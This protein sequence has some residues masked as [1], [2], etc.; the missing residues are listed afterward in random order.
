MNNSFRSEAGKSGENSFPSS[1]APLMP[2]PECA[3]NPA[4]PADYLRFL[5]QFPN[6]HADLA[7]NPALPPDLVQ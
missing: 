2:S 1:A 7:L 3:R 4:T 5:T 6:L